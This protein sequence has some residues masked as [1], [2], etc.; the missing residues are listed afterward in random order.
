M[1][2]NG[3]YTI[4]AFLF[5]YFGLLTSCIDNLESCVDSEAEGN[6]TNGYS[7]QLTVTLDNMG[8][9]DRRASGENNP[10]KEW[11]DYIDP[12]KFRV[13]F[14]NHKEE[15]LFESKS[16]WIKQLASTTQGYAQWLVSVPMYSYGNDNPY[17]WNWT[18][19]RKALT[20]NKFKI[21]IL[22]NRPENEYYPGFSNT[23]FKRDDKSKPD[24]IPNI[25]PE[26]NAENTC[27]GAPQGTK[28]KKIFDLHHCQYDPIY[29]AKSRDADEGKTSEYDVYDFIMDEYYDVYNNNP[30]AAFEDYKPK[31]GATSS[32]VEWDEID[33]VNRVIT[34]EKGIYPYT[35]DSDL[36]GK[37]TQ[38]HKDRKMQGQF[39][40]IKYTV[41]P[42][43][44]HPIPMYGVQEFEP[45]TN[46]VKGT[47]FN[48]SQITGNATGYK[49]ES[50]ALLRSVVK[51]ELLL[52]KKLFPKQTKFVT[53]WYSNVYARCEPMDVWTSTKDLWKD[54]A[55]NSDKTKQCEWF[56]IIDF[57][58][59]VSKNFKLSG[60][61]NLN[62]KTD[63]KKDFQTTLSW[64]YG[65]W[66]EN[67]PDNIKRWN[68]YDHGYKG[69]YVITEDMAGLPFPRIF[70]PCVQR[71]KTLLCTHEGDLSDKFNDN[72]WH[73]VVYTGER[74]MLDANNLPLLETKH[75]YATSWVFKDEKNKKY[76]AIPI[77]GYNDQGN[78]VNNL[79]KDCFGP[80]DV[81]AFDSKYTLELPKG[82]MYSYGD[83]VR[84][85]AN[86]PNEWPWPL[87]RNHVYRITIGPD[88][89]ASSA[90]AVSR[91]ALETGDFIIQSEEFH[92]ETLTDE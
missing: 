53:L 46:W 75:A 30:N 81:D 60:V 59:I 27:W 33:L 65:A 78:F 56:N 14:F 54:H 55:K 57:G 51:L 12:E 29:H 91:R 72:Y 4:I 86:T 9:S 77:A 88:E 76:Y 7:L 61:P 23:G 3:K 22:A 38:D 52:S 36:D 45:I 92:S 8:G 32:W 40:P 64:F 84:D 26:W 87:L 39:N 11:E 48:L 18:E 49:F 50:I 15:F 41:L 62:R 74:N 2:N 43:A 70:N 16:R 83:D 5:V 85:K 90:D 63:Y 89:P 21:A 73:I 19:I 68:F 25:G 34:K 37:S 44:K 58:P 42:S 82:N 28:P 10:M 6:F 31:M 1:N 79:A 71:Q 13:L 24:W 17:N 67:G 35:I 69:E 20:T 80:H 66:T 47:P